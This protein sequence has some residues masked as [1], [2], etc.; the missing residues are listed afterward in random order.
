[1]DLPEKPVHPEGL[2]TLLDVKELAVGA[3]DITRAS[4]GVS[5][6]PCASQLHTDLEIPRESAGVEE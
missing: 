3:G 5:G 2:R 1:M 4:R 6:R